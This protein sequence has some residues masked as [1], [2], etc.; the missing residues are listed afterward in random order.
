M[1]NDP[2]LGLFAALL[3]SHLV[4]LDIGE[5]L[6]WRLGGELGLLYYDQNYHGPGPQLRGGPVTKLAVTFAERR[7]EIGALIDVSIVTGPS[8]HSFE[9]A[10]RAGYLF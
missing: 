9:A 2:G 10:L 1:N 4:S 6:I 8:S 5:Y 3:R 7:F